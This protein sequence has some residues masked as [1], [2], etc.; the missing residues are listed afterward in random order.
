MPNELYPS[1]SIVAP[2]YNEFGNVEKLLDEIFGVMGTYTSEWEVVI[3]DDGST[4]GTTELLER[5]TAGRPWLR[6][7][8]LTKN[9]GQTAAISAGVDH[10]RGEV[11]VTIDADLQNDPRDIYLLLYE[12]RKGYDVV[13]GWRRHRKDSFLWRTLP[14]RLANGLISLI[15]GV[16]LRDYGCT[17]KAYHRDV[18]KS[19][20]IYGRLHRFLPALC[21]WRGAS[22][23]EVAVNHRS[24][25]AG[26]SKYGLSK[27]FGVVLDLITVKFLLD[28]TDA[29]MRV[30]GG[31][32]VV[33]GLL[34]AIGL[35][36]LSWVKFFLLQ[37]IADRPLL[38]IS[39]LLVMLGTQL[40]ALGLLTEL[41]V[42]IYYESQ[43]K[44]VY[45]IKP[46]RKYSGRLM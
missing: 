46:E 24:R 34:G 33:C 42:R 38:M 40:L 41:S 39:V 32:G 10:A 15:T 28:Y 21:S 27:T 18:I 26:K 14:S 4:D 13:S 37:P 20:R 25:V 7:L 1:L 17:L 36:Y 12:M 3:V 44:P 8:K 31:A 2:V 22:V 19:I 43:G 9:F 6:I 35:A 11:I 29:P 23:A 45:K 5:L 16:H 30:F